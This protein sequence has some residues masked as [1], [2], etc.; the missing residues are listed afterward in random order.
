MTIYVG[1]A[2]G[3]VARKETRGEERTT[4]NVD[5]IIVIYPH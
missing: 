4:I 5:S 1:V 2:A 3:G